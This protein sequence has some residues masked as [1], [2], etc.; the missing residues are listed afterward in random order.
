VEQL[1]VDFVRRIADYPAYW[2]PFFAQVGLVYAEPKPCPAVEAIPRFSA[3]T[4]TVETPGF[5]P[6]EFEPEWVHGQ[7]EYRIL[8]PPGTIRGG[9]LTAKVAGLPDFGSFTATTV[10]PEPI[11][12]TT[13]FPRGSVLR[14]SGL[15]VRWTGGDPDSQVTVALHMSGHQYGD[16]MAVPASLGG[17]GVAPTLTRNRTIDEIRIYQR[18]VRPQQ[19]AAPGFVSLVHEYVYEWRFPLL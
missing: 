8:L 14:F 15:T 19:T 13:E 16:S 7:P 9:E 5:G 17:I 10:A 2:R 12:I 4:V 11:R 18:G 6:A 1:H 3:G